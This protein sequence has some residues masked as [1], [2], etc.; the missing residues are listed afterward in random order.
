MTR[1]EI[2]NH[3]PDKVIYKISLLCK[4]LKFAITPNK[5]ADIMLPFELLFGV[6]RATVHLFFKP[7][8]LNQTLYSPHFLPLI[9]L[10]TTKIKNN[11]SKEELKALHNLR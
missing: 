5:L 9:V 7:K 10:I 8:P 11:L 3:D 2:C 1:L 4:G 6:I